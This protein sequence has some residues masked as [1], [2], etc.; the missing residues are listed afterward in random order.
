MQSIS[1]LPDRRDQAIC[2]FLYEYAADVN[3]L[4]DYVPGLCS[5]PSIPTAN[6]YLYNTIELIGLGHLSSMRYGN[7]CCSDTEIEVYKKH[8]S[9]LQAVNGALCNPSLVTKD[10]T[11]VTIMLLGLFEVG[12]LYFCPNSHPEGCYGY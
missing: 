9:V 12:C 2:L 5:K 6:G 3:G 8:G 7:P 11:L 10:E 1:L 4:Y